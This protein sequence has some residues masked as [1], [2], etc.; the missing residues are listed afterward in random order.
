M[1]GFQTQSNPNKCKSIK[2]DNARSQGH[3]IGTKSIKLGQKRGNSGKLS[4]SVEEGFKNSKIRQQFD[5]NR[6]LSE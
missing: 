6:D 3:G 5:L 4:D 2:T 1:L